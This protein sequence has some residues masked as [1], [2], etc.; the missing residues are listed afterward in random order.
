M[1]FEMTVALEVKDE[2]VYNN[3]RK[4]MN[5]ILDSFSGEILYDFKVSKVLKSQEEGKTNRVFI[6]K[7]ISEKNMKNFFSNEE[8]LEVK[9]KYFDKAV[10][11]V[12]IL[13]SHKK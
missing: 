2:E 9:A 10:G 4:G 6:L 1:A 3:Y 5:H 13:S 12:H 8:Y 7:F 11:N